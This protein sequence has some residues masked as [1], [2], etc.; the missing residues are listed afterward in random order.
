M[1]LKTE[2]VFEMKEKERKILVGI[3]FCLL[4]CSFL[5]LKA[6]SE[7][8]QSPEPTI[9][10]L[11]A[12]LPKESND[13]QSGCATL[14]ILET[15]RENRLKSEAKTESTTSYSTRRPTDEYGNELDWKQHLLPQIYITA[16]SIIHWTN[17]LD[18]GNLTKI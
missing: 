9:S 18:G 3:I 1:H 11:L 16:H 17:G 6:K 14:K 15:L 12:T 10:Q 7:T 2:D 5:P 8:P 4:V 13:S